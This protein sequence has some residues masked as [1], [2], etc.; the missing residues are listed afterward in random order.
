M[1][2]QVK[3]TDPVTMALPHSP[4]ARQGS[5][6]E[7]GGNFPLSLPLQKGGIPLFGKVVSHEP[8]DLSAKSV[9]GLRALF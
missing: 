5:I 1:D 4:E 9:Y 2:F 8:F 3:I 7:P 6:S